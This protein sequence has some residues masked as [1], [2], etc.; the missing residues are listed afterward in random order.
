MIIRVILLTLIVGLVY[1]AVQQDLR[2]GANDP[3]IQMAEDAAHA[4]AQGVP[5]SSVI[6]KETID[7]AQSIAPFIEAFDEAGNPLVSSGLLRGVVSHLPAGVFAYTKQFGEDR[8][9]WQPEP[10]VR[11]AAVVVRF[12]GIQNGF[13]VAGRSLR[14]VEKREDKLTLQV[15]LAWTLAVMVIGATFVF[16]LFRKRKKL[17]Y[18]A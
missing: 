2:Q 1:G 10:G 13:V 12:D 4:L 8:I 15:F 14:E 7:I 11:I 3:Q 9:T 17:R 16:D 18:R 5:P 6:P